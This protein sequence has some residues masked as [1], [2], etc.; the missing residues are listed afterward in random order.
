MR[1]TWYVLE[2]GEPVCPSEVTPKGDRLVHKSGVL[3][4]MKGAVPFTR[5]VD[6]AEERAKAKPEK[7]E[8][9]GSYKTRESKAR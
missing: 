9:K 4:A 3:V 5:N 2:T 6:P 1:D 8:P 7:A